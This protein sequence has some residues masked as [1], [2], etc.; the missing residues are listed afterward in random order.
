MMLLLLL[1]LLLFLLS[2][3]FSG[4]ET[5]FLTANRLRIEH[6]AEKGDARSRIALRLFRKPSRLLS[7]VLVGNNIVNVSS[8]IIAGIILK[9]MLGMSEAWANFIISIGLTVLLLIA[10]EIIPKAISQRRADTVTLHVARVFQLVT[11]LFLPVTLFVGAFSS[12]VLYFTKKKA[13]AQGHGR[14]REDIE[15]L[16]AIGVEEGIISPSTQDFIHSVFSFG[17][18]TVREIMTPLVDVVSIEQG[19][20][21][22]T[23]ARLIEESGF[24]RIPVYRERVDDVLG[25]VSV[26]DLVHSKKRD[27]LDNYIRPA[28]FVPET[29]RIDGLLVE[30]RQAGVPLVFV[31]DEWGGTAGVVSHEDIAEHIVG[32]IRDRG[33]KEVPEIQTVGQGY[34]VDGLTD[35]DLLAEVTGIKV[36]KDGFETVAGFVCYLA[37]KI[38]AKGDV[39]EYGGYR[40]HVEEADATSVGTLCFVRSG[41]ERTGSKIKFLKKKDGKTPPGEKKS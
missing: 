3:F 7:T 16:A 1:M 8:S 24:S 2:A 17:K 36:R 6:A 19:R 20:S 4:S 12:F 5:A 15:I 26:F 14:S 9:E 21:I 39:L 30:M 29:K 31:V 13:A 38:P 10:G 33:G 37:Q 32:Q 40:I 41:S 25:Y 27:K 28:L 18:T 23:A 35:V 34:L 22:N 11:W